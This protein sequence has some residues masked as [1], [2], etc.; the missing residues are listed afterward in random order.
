MTLYKSV[1]ESISLLCR[2][3]KEGKISIGEF[4]AGLLANIT[5]I[6][7]LEDKNIRNS[8]HNLEAELDGILAL[9]YGG[10][11]IDNL[12]SIFIN[13]DRCLDELIIPIIQK[14]QDTIDPL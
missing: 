3:C 5:Q 6:I 12:N 10:S 14:M 2:N 9:Y 13:N 8:L 7:S 4:Q 1:D 11:E